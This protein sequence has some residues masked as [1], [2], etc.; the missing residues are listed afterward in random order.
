MNWTGYAVTVLVLI[1]AFLAT[2]YPVSPHFADRPGNSYKL[3]SAA[4]YAWLLVHY[5]LGG[6]A[7]SVALI[8]GVRNSVIENDVRQTV[9]VWTW[10]IAA[11]AV[12]VIIASRVY[13]P[14]PLQKND[15]FL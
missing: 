13:M 8:G 7:V 14:V 4:Y 5:V 3:Q 6:L 2:G 10:S 1:F 15:T 12:W 9:Q 11:T